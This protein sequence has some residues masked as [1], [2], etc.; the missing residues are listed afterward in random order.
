MNISVLVFSPIVYGDVCYF[1]EVRKSIILRWGPN[2]FFRGDTP[3]T[4]FLVDA[5]YHE[6]PRIKNW[7]FGSKSASCH[8]FLVRTP[9]NGPKIPWKRNI[10]RTAG[11]TRL[12]D[13]SFY[14]EY[15]SFYW[16]LIIT[17]S[18]GQ[19]KTIRIIFYAK[20]RPLSQKILP[21]QPDGDLGYDG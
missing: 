7:P 12:V 2:D 17:M 10:S 4:S 8:H 16:C 6:T 19:H 1:C 11:R 9:K 20:L 13:P 14:A 3:S 18:K 21:F 5:M 15:A